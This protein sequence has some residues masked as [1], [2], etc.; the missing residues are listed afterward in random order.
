[1]HEL[2]I[3]YFP[4][5]KKATCFKQLWEF[6]QIFLIGLSLGSSLIISDLST[7]EDVNESKCYASPPVSN[8]AC[9][10]ST[11]T[12]PGENEIRC[13]S[14]LEACSFSERLPQRY[15][16][17]DGLNV[18]EYDTHPQSGLVQRNDSD[19]TS[20][21]TCVADPVVMGACDQLSRVKSTDGWFGSTLS[22]SFIIPSFGCNRLDEDLSTPMSEC[23]ISGHCVDANELSRSLRH[24]RCGDSN[25]TCKVTV[26]LMTSSTWCRRRERVWPFQH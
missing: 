6:T 4:S 2:Y 18:M 9:L 20:F 12:I 24:R 22:L 17:S 14:Y 11:E 1:M 13:P 8:E 16:T 19:T 5:P 10:M 21:A 26:L 25:F 23:L 7:M 15:P 3:F